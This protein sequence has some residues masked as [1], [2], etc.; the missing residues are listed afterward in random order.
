MT[1]N[2][3]AQQTY[4]AE[5]SQFLGDIKV[6]SELRVDGYIKGTVTVSGPLIIGPNGKIE[7]EIA[8]RAATV[9]GTILGNIKATE[10]IILDKGSKLYGD[11]QTRELA[12]HEGA[13]FQGHSS[14]QTDGTK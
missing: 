9:A 4:I 1:K 3:A 6:E 12:I 2:L 14:M 13:F 7:G 10:K 5:G 11:L 8:A